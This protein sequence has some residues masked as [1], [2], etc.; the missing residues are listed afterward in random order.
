[1]TPLS[2]SIIAVL[3]VGAA[4]AWPAA[5][6][7]TQAAKIWET[8]GFKNPE[9]ALFDKAAA[10][11]YVSNVNGEATGKDGNGFISKVSPDGKVL[12]M[13]W[14]TGLDAPKGLAK[15]G[16][17]LYTADIDKLVEIDPASGKILNR[18]EAKNAK[19]LNDVA[20]D[21][22]GNVYVSDMA[23][24]TIW[25]LANGTFE[26]FLNDEKLES[27]N[28]LLA[29][30]DDLIVGSWGVMTDGMA[31]KVPGHLKAV[32]LK[33][34]SIRSLGTGTPIGNLDA[35]EPLGDG[36]Y[37][38]TDWVAGKVMRL[39]RDGTVQV[40]LA[41]GQGTADLGYDPGTGTAFIPQMKTGIL[42]GFKVE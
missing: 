38:V 21:A 1:M 26:V 41:L 27:P 18:Y 17:K 29:D 19:F 20:A 13:E 11:V 30:G 14:A 3:A 10:V 4:S 5:A 7:A 6:S 33:D 24:N 28:G 9:S 31:T 35:V 25:R 15:A 23:T 2:R 40:L 12:V 34:K 39:G 22:S 16:G 37:L 8:P 32:S 42:Y 36:T